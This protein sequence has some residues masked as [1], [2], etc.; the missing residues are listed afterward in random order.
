MTAAQAGQFEQ[1]PPAGQVEG[2]EHDAPG[3]LRIAG[4][5]ASATNIR[6][7]RNPNRPNERRS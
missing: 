6:R 5:E 2:P 3:Q 7:V 1:A 4:A